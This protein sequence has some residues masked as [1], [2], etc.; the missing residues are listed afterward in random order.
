MGDEVSVP[1]SGRHLVAVLE[2]NA[3]FNESRKTASR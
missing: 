2:K 3:P 1:A